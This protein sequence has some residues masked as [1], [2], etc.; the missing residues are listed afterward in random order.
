M[1]EGESIPVN[2]TEETGAPAPAQDLVHLT[3]D[4]AY[5]LFFYPHTVSRDERVAFSEG[6][7]LEEFNVML[8]K[9]GIPN[10]ASREIA[11]KVES[12]T[13]PATIHGFTKDECR[14]FIDSYDDLVIDGL[15]GNGL[16]S[17]GVMEISMR[18]TNVAAQLGIFEPL[19][20]RAVADFRP[21]AALRGRE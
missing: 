3:D 13:G 19:A 16:E 1:D 2:T 18:L 9:I 14:L 21:A 5:L 4:P 7:L 6:A 8:I 17:Q 11:I 12:R 15:D 20:S 10:I